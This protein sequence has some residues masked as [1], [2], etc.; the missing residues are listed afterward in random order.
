MLEDYLG[1][2]CLHT[3]ICRFPVTDY[4]QKIHFKPIRLGYETKMKLMLLTYCFNTDYKVQ[5]C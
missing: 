3:F 1:A 2:D 4:M 5:S